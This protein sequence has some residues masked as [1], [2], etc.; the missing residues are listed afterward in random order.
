M[1]QRP[2]STKQEYQKLIDAQYHQMM[3]EFP[4]SMGRVLMLYIEAK[5]N[6][7]SVQAFVD[8]GAQSTI[9]SLDCAKH[10]KIDH[11][12]D[13]RFAGTAVG[14][15]TGKIIGRVHLVGLQIQTSFFPCTVTVMEN[16]NMDFL[17]GL[18]ML[19]RHNCCIDLEQSCLRFK[20]GPGQYFST[21]FL[22]EK[23]V[24]VSKGG[25]KGFDAEKANQEVEELRAR[26]RKGSED[27]GDDDS[28]AMKD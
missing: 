10:C 20:L 12:I 15:G 19:K 1:I 8:S 21:P 18:D 27:E 6:N 25:T 17:L 22:H 13:T 3:A 4:E 23:D 2:R 16:P 11:L 9:M 24:D 26:S 14:V 7:E 28:Q 5:V